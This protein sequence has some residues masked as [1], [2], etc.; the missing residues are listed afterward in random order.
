MKNANFYFALA[1]SVLVTALLISV[2]L[3]FSPGLLW[4]VF[5]CPPLVWWPLSALLGSRAATSAFALLSFLS[6]AVY[7]SLLNLLFFRGHP[8]VIYIVFALCW[9]PLTI[10]FAGQ[11][12]PFGY[13][14]AGTAVTSVFF[15]AVNLITSP[16]VIWFVFPVFAVLWWPLSVYFFVYKKQKL[17]QSSTDKPSEKETHL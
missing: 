1:G 12:N 14:L 8:W 9:W 13:S 10:F 7:Y 11:K 5:A 15:I 2:N 4:V 16:Q 3:L 6:A 17:I